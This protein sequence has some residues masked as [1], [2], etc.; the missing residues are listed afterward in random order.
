AR[1]GSRMAGGCSPAHAP[2]LAA[3]GAEGARVDLAVVQPPPVPHRQRASGA[4][5]PQRSKVVIAGIRPRAA[6]PPSPRR[7][8]PSTLPGVPDID[9]QLASSIVERLGAI[10][11][12]RRDSVSTSDEMA[13]WTARHLMDAGGK[14][15]RPMLVLLAASLGDVDADG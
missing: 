14:R 1:F 13:R 12:R 4:D 15:V 3:V 11:E 9:E 2:A 7:V 6:S 10:E 8:M 5:P